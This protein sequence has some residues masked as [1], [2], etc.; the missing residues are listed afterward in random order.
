MKD[1]LKKFLKLIVALIYPLVKMS[2]NIF[3]SSKSLLK[4]NKKNA[5]SAAYKSGKQYSA[6]EKDSKWGSKKTF[7][8]DNKPLWKNRKLILIASA[9]LIILATV[10]TLS[11]SGKSSDP[12]ASF[13]ADKGEILADAALSS[14]ESDTGVTDNVIAEKN[15]EKAILSISN[16]GIYTPLPDVSSDSIPTTATE[17]TEL[18]PGCHD[19]RISDIQTRLMDLDYMDSDEPTD[20]YGWGTQYSLELFQR[21][22]GLQ[23]DGLAGENTL[24]ALFSENAMPYTVKLGDRGSDVEEIQVRLK[25]LKYL[26]AS[27]TGKFGTDTETAV[28]GFQKRNDLSP[29]GNVGVQTKEQLFSED[30]IP[31]PTATPS[32]TKKPSPTKKPSASNKPTETDK[33]SPTETEPGASDQPADPDETSAEALIAF[34]KTKLGCK[35]VGGGKGPN[36]FDCSGFVYY[37]LN[38][39]GYKIKY[40]TSR[41]W[42]KC[43]LPKISDFGDMKPG[44][45]ICYS[46]N[47]VGIFIGNGQM[48]DASSSN[49]KVVQRSCT[50][51][52]WKS[53]FICARRVF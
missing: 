21:N 28:K 48:I 26:K 11:L 46:P 13:H 35:Y 41:S 16:E 4:S 5:V 25:E 49:G 52:Y 33:P 29:D 1:F 39:V 14:T 20:Y 27:A 24:T 36:K 15:A 30:A 10:L 38:H 32:A 31:A 3:R 53:H 40:M 43:S 51:S 7:S 22:N 47:H 18:V 34:A 9:F 2:R 23:V 37:C 19:P 17:Q 6:K 44:D 50:S 8:T 12:S 45:I 42:A